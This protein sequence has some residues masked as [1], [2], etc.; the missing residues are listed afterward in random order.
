MTPTLSA[1]DLIYVHANQTSA[2]A[3]QAS[4]G[5]VALADELGYQ[6]YWFAEHHNMPAIASTSPAVLI[7]AA[8]G[9][10]SRIRLG[11]G[12]VMLPN[13]SPFIIAEQFAALE[14]IAP[15]R[16]DLGIGRAPGSD[17]VVSYL[18]RQD[19]AASSVN[20]FPQNV[21]SVRA[22]VSPEGAE[23]DLGPRGTYQVKA[24]GR[25]ATAPEIWLLGSSNYSAELA[26]RLSL[27]YV[28]ANHFA[29]RGI[30]EAMHI[31]R[32][33]FQPSDAYPQPTSFV[34]VNVA[35]AETAEEAHLRALPHL[36]AHA[37]LRLNRPLIPT[38]TAETARDAAPDPQLD[39]LVERL[40]DVWVIGTPEDAMARISKL[41]SDNGVDE[42]MVVPQLS[43]LED[44]PADQA[45]GVD[46]TLR[47]LAAQA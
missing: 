6:R 28:F 2:E 29:G 27:P 39:P 45:I 23:L 30:E 14:G 13:H 4:L 43:P 21:M 11:S 44:E 34:T 41:A 17:T 38:E 10:T 16:I 24:T 31:Y 20:E 8:T 22:L 46:N 25:P 5:T 40:R 33:S 32:S 12:G 26:A 18:L 37:G 9:R 36:R 15:G 1:L 3:I 47:L 42:V 19:G 7:A 35:V